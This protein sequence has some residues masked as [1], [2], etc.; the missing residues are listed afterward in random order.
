[1][2]DKTTAA[3]AL[4]KFLKNSG[5]TCA[6]AGNDMATDVLTSPGKALE[7]GAENGSLAVY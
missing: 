5:S 1:M 6:T 3:N 7:C 4:G 2:R